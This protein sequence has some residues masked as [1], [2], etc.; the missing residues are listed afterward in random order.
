MITKDEH[1]MA[2]LAYLADAE[3]GAKA[4]LNMNRKNN[5]VDAIYNRLYLSFTGTIDERKA[6]AKCSVEYQSALD[7][8]AVAD[9][10]WTRHL[11][12]VE[13]C[14]AIINVWEREKF[15]A[16]QAERVR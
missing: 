1:V 11:G 3:I 7:R 6:Q 15:D 14:K 13:S 5:E 12:E 2:A 9:S 10:D 8:A 4:R 16:Y